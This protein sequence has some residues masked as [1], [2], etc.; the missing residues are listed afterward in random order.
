VERE[1][2]RVGLTE[3]LG[4]PSCGRPRKKTALLLSRDAA[5]NNQQMGRAGPRDDGPRKKTA[6]L[7][8]CKNLVPYWLLKETWSG[9]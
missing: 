6:L 7:L 1:D 3:R 5:P 8:S 4:A 2:A 9:L